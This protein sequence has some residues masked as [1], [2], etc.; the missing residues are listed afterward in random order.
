MMKKATLAII[1]IIIIIFTYSIGYRAFYDNRTANNLSSY[2]TIDFRG[3]ID[4]TTNKVT[5]ATLS[6]VDYRFSSKPIE[7]F[8]IIDVDD[9]TYKIAADE[10]SSFPPTYSPNDFNLQ[11]CFKY[12]NSLLVHFEP[13]LLKEINNAKIVKISFKYVGNNS[14]IELPLSEVD[15]KYWKKQLILL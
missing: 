8:C 15:L 4:P 2:C 12:T 5:I 14:A 1:T 10:T 11:S 9:K 3:V 6:L 13:S 7:K